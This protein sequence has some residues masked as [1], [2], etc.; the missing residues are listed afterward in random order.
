M[1]KRTNEFFFT[2]F[3]GGDAVRYCVGGGFRPELLDWKRRNRIECRR[4][5][6]LRAGPEQGGEAP[7]HKCCRAL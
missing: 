1:N 5:G 3:Y 4:T 7:A 6:D 2:N